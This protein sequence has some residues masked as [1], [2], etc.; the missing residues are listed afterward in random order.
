MPQALFID[1]DFGSQVI[2]KELCNQVGIPYIG[3]Q[4]S[5]QVEGMLDSFLDVNVVLLDLEMPH[6]NGYEI[7]KVLRKH[8]LFSRVPIVAC[9]VHSI[10]MEKA[11]SAGFDSFI[12]KPLNL[13][14]FLDQ[15][16]EIIGGNPVWETH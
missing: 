9:T 4:D 8:P 15:L 3:V 16:N 14:T 6:R 7:L 13:E 10:E 5:T 11:R 2:F 12:V 1:N